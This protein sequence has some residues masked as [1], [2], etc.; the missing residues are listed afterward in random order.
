[1]NIKFTLS[2]RRYSVLGLM[3]VMLFW[4][5]GAAAFTPND[6][7]LQQQAY[8]ARVHAFGGWDSVMKAPQADPIVVAV[9]DTGV[10]I[11]HPD[12]KDSIWTNPKEIAGNG[13]DDDNNSFVDDVHGWNFVE[14]NNNPT[15]SILGDYDAEAVDHGT[16]VAGIIGAGFDNG[17]GVAGLVPRVKIMPLRAL[18]SSGSGNTLVLAQAVNYAVDNGA[19]VINLS[20]VGKISDPVLA[21][22]IDNAY[23]HGVAIVAAAGNEE[24]TGLDL[25]KTPR[26]PICDAANVNQ[27]F[28]VASIDLDNGL[29]NFSNYGSSCVDAV[30]PGTQIY[31]TVPLLAAS[32]SFSE[33]YQGGWAGTSVAA[34]IVSSL[35]A[36]VM[37]VD[38]RL[39]LDRIY[40]LIKKHGIDITSANP[41]HYLDLGAGLVDFQSVLTE[42]QQLAERRENMLVLGSQRGTTTVTIASNS[43]ALINSFQPYTAQFTGG[44]NIATA[45][46]D[47]DGTLEIITAPHSGGGPHV[48]IFDQQGTVK[49]QF[50]A[51]DPK[52]RGGLSLAVGDID[53]DGVT[54]IVTAPEAGGSPHVRIFDKQGK[55][56]GQFMAYSESFT[57]GVRVAVGDVDGDGKDEIITVPASGGGPHVRI[58]DQQGTVKGQFM[59]F[60]PAERSGYSLAV[61]NVDNDRLAEIIV[62]D[63]ASAKGTLRIFNVNGEEKNSWLVFSGLQQKSYKSA[64][65]AQDITGDAIPDII[66]Y[67]VLSGEG[68]VNVYDY[69]GQLVTRI[70]PSVINNNGWSIAALYK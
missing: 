66:V 8:L 41:H 30:A 34:P 56:K 20:L 23:I 36:N 43:G 48:R 64:V 35:I 15:P 52:F 16:V 22:A 44:V 6:P 37:I 29:S 27:V 32:G 1:M 49:G 63:Q 2:A 28:G 50:M 3:G 39:S 46:L 70:T 68:T 24:V 55:L 67:P 25:D 45:D 62:I 19:R 18:D 38:P 57:G 10:D 5:V 40:G 33:P 14:S 21:Q 11:N 4:S 69:T 7:Q 60:G 54:D 31:S 65:I 42:A 13:V 26:Y 59:A 17:I 53:G 58:F 61:A 12:L 51:Y 9:L 47:G